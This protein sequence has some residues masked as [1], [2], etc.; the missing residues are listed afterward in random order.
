[1]IAYW[2]LGAGG[3][4][5]ALGIFLLLLRRRKFPD[6][7][8]QP[9]QANRLILRDQLAELESERKAGAISDDEYAT[10]KN[11]LEQRAL[12]EVVAHQTQSAAPTRM[13]KT[14]RWLAIAALV[15]FVPLAASLLYWQLGRPDLIN[16]TPDTMRAPPTTAEP[17]GGLADLDGLAQRLSARLEATGKDDG[18]GWA[19]LARTYVELKRYPQ[20]V[21][22]F[23]RAHKLLGDDAQMLADYADAHAMENE[24]QFDK[25]SLDLVARALK[26]DPANPKA[27]ELD[28][29]IAYNNGNYKKAVAQWQK[30]LPLVEADSD[31]ARVIAAN[32]AEANTRAGLPAT[33]MMPTAATITA[34]APTTVNNA[35]VKGTVAIA[36]ALQ[37]KLSPSD[38]LFVFARAPTGSKAPIAIL[39]ATAKELP[40]AFNLDDSTAMIAGNKLSAQREVAIV[41]RI[42]KSGSAIPQAGDLEGMAPL[43]KIGAAGVRI[44]IAREIK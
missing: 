44:E 15:L 14:S 26:A 9:T 13:K 36:P 1:M 16:S 37:S 23:E 25:K 12:A 29:S 35:G 27:I 38:T 30:L 43:V 34:P 41:A 4:A 32:I 10:M 8:F 7:E 3:L 31:H 6:A 24:R 40:F 20:A 33:S 18:A 19:L 42:S 21:I 39:R 11:D 5:V 17:H 28:A 2:A 22:A